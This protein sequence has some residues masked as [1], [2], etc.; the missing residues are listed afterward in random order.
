M[1]M[2]NFVL[3]NYDKPSP[4]GVSCKFFKIDDKFGIKVYTS[5][6]TRDNAVI[7]QQKM[8]SHGYAP[9]VGESFNI[10]DKFF[11]YI[12]EIAIPIVEGTEE[13]QGPKHYE[14]VSEAYKKEP[15]I[16]NEIDKLCRDMRK[17]GYI[18]NDQHLA[19]FGRMGEK[20]VCIDFGY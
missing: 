2:A 11:C 15:F 9:A 17:A 6:Y 4:G 13:Y 19:N 20:L 3:S 14:I 5:E 18:M 16:R 12:T 10:Q 7:R 1:D 8:H